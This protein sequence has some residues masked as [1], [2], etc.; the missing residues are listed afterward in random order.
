VRARRWAYVLTE[1]HVMSVN[2]DEEDVRW[3]LQGTTIHTIRG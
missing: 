1:A 2:D 3:G